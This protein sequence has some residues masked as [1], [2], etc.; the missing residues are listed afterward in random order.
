MKKFVVAA[1][2][3]LSLSAG[4]FA[5]SDNSLQDRLMTIP[6]MVKTMEIKAGMLYTSME[7]QEAGL[8]AEDVIYITVAPATN[9]QIDDMMGASN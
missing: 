9:A 2:M 5:Q 4:A 1:A 7:L 6:M 3:L 8:M